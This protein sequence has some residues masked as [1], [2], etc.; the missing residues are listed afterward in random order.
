MNR[1]QYTIQDHREDPISFNSVWDEKDIVL[2]AIDAAEHYHYDGGWEH[3]G[4]PLV[5]T[6]L[7]DGQVVGGAEIDRRS[8]PEFFAI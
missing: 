4:W 5:F 2:L 1:Y 8:A 7:L 3:D 6:I